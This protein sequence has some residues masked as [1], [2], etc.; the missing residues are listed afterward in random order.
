MNHR[1]YE[2]RHGTTAFALAVHFV[3]SVML[4][5]LV[6]LVLFL[7][8]VDMH[9]SDLLMCVLRLIRSSAH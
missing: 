6:R 7:A 9:D 3:V 5:L 8:A 1:P 4:V 2:A